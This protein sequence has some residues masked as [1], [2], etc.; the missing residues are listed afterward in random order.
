MMELYHPSVKYS[1]GEGLKN[2]KKGAPDVSGAPQAVEKV[3]GLF[4]QPS[5]MPLLSRRTAAQKSSLR[6]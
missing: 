4:R 1:I 5:K 2:A 6:S 3:P